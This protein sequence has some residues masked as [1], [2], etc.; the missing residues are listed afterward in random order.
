MRSKQS[1]L[2]DPN[3][4][5]VPPFK[6]PRGR[7]NDKRKHSFVER[8]GGGRKRQR[9]ICQRCFKTGHTKRSDKCEL[10]GNGN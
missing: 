8:I 1:A 5:L 3:I 6:M 7:P 9:M 4:K 10:K 2:Y